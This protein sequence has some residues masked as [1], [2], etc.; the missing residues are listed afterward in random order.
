MRKLRRLPKPIVIRKPVNRTN[1][2]PKLGTI[3]SDFEAEY[4]AF[5]QKLRKKKEK[6]EKVTETETPQDIQSDRQ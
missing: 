1:E 6:N 2:N 3:E 4:Q 5:I